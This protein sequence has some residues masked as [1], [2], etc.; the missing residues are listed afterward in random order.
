LRGLWFEASLSKKLVTLH[1]NKY[2]VHGDMYC[3]PSCKGGMG[4]RNDIP[5]WPRVRERLS[6]N[7]VKSK[8]GLRCGS[9]GR[10][11]A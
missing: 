7:K 8:K 11:L 10:T 4:R 2:A 3:N 5:D 1:L 9:S 6:K